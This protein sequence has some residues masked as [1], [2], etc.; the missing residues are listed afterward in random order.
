MARK[1]K[2]ALEAALTHLRGEVTTSLL[3]LDTSVQELVTA[4]R[5]GS[6]VAHGGAVD[7]LR[8]DFKQ[9]TGVLD[10]LIRDELTSMGQ[11]AYR[12]EAEA[13]RYHAARLERAAGL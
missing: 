12:Y 6:G 3:A 8:M 13:K 4:G 2:Q 10:R 7:A 1:Q 9:V 11:M 5:N